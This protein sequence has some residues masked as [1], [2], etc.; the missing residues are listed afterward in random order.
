MNT[1]L[2]IPEY[3]SDY[4]N[5][6]NRKSYPSKF[7]KYLEETRDFFSELEAQENI[8]EIAA[9]TVETLNSMVKGL[10]KQRQFCDIEFFLMEYACPAALEFGTEKSKDFAEK[11]RDAWAQSHPKLRFELA[12]FEKFNSNFNTAIF[13]INMNW[14]GNK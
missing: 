4:L 6:F 5:A 12:D 2:F 3:I 8:E 7:K 14:G 13:G 11:L 1:K 9:Q 10:W